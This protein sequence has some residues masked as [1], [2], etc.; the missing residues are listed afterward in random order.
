MSRYSVY[1]YHS[2]VADF[3]PHRLFSAFGAEVLLPDPLLTSVPEASFRRLRRKKKP[4]L[5]PTQRT[6][7]QSGLHRITE[8]KHT[9]PPLIQTKSH[10]RRGTTPPSSPRKRTATEKYLSRRLTRFS[11]MT[12]R[13]LSPLQRKRECFSPPLRIT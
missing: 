13:A 7:R 11:R 12:R 3:R 2:S 8:K 9:P 10:R 6:L 1:A 4:P 5:P